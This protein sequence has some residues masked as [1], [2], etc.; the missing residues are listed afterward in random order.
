MLNIYK[1]NLRRV[2]KHGFYIFGC[3]VAF[4]GTMLSAYMPIF[5]FLEGKTPEI[6]MFFV[7]AAM[8]AYFTIFIPIFCNVEYSDGVIRNKVIAGYSQT[9]IF[10]G[11]LLTQFTAVFIMWG[12]Y[13]LGGLVGGARPKGEELIS[14]IVVLFAVF[15]YAAVIQALSFRLRKPVPLVVS[16]AFLFQY[17]FSSV[18][19]GNAI[20]MNAKGTSAFVGSLIYNIPSLGQWFS[21]SGFADDIANPGA[22]WQLGMSLLMIAVAGILGLYGIEKRNLE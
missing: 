4:L 18:M 15:A 1:A 22:L 12:F 21:R 6:R 13:M 17:C 14:N 2:L 9:R 7:S 20:L 10:L 16:S 11:H 8:V 19:F 3:I 5:P